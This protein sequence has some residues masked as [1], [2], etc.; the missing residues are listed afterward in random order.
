MI[1]S[2]NHDEYYTGADFL[3]RF[4]GCYRTYKE[5]S[6]LYLEAVV[7]SSDHYSNS[8]C[9]EYGIRLMAA[10]AVDIC[11]GTDML[12]VTTSSWALR[13]Y[14]L[15]KALRFRFSKKMQINFRKAKADSEKMSNQA[16]EVWKERGWS[17]SYCQRQLI[18]NRIDDL[19]PA[20]CI[21]ELSFEEFLSLNPHPSESGNSDYDPYDNIRRLLRDK[22]RKP[23][24]DKVRAIADKTYREQVKCIF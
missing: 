5:S 22:T 8:V 1:I 12:V 14:Y 11:K 17:E 20:L 13:D 21:R 4:L 15:L 24:Y 3:G 9:D 18:Y 6:P 2:E 23:N 19:L 7:F 16:L 10:E